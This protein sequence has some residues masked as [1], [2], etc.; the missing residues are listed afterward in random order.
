[1]GLSSGCRGAAAHEA[2]DLSPAGIEAHSAAH[3]TL[4]SA[5]R[6]LVHRGHNDRY[7]DTIGEPA[8]EE[9]AVC[10]GEKWRASPEVD[11]VGAHFLGTL[12]EKLKVIASGLILD[13]PTL[14]HTGFPCAG[15]SRNLLSLLC[16]SSISQQGY[17]SARVDLL[18]SYIK[19]SLMSFYIRASLLA[20]A[21][22]ASAP[23]F[24]QD[25][26][27]WL[28]EEEEEET[29]SERP[30]DDEGDLEDEPDEND[31]SWMNEFE[32]EGEE[33]DFGEDEFEEDRDVSV[34]GEGEDNAQIYRDQM[35]RVENLLPDEEALSWERYMKKY[36]N[37]VFKARID[38]RLTDLEGEMYG[39]RIA[40]PGGSAEDAGKVEM[41]FAQP[42][43]LEN[44]D[45]ITKLRVGFEWG[46]PEYI[47][48]ITDYEHQIFRE[49]SVHV[50]ARNR[51]SSWSIE[52][53]ARYSLIK[54]ARTRTW[55]TAIG[56]VRI[57]TNPIYPAIRPQLAFGQR[58]DLGSTGWL[59]IQLQGGSDLAFVKDANT[60]D[61][62]FDPRVVGGAN[63]TFVPA[64]TVRIYMET[65][66]TMKALAWDG[67]NS[68]RFNVLTFGLK[69]IGRQK[70]GDP[71]YEIGAG[72]TAPYSTNYWGY[73]VGS[74]TGDLNYYL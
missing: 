69:I 7:R 45:P 12:C 8:I 40:S 70:S 54:S 27:D 33:L 18:R 65:S 67:G 38:A 62:L 30:S 50:G 14:V 58:L 31:E 36:P 2:T 59:D 16:H 6:D 52:T 5:H 42:L 21:L 29:P 35:D 11:E 48:L 56:D 72:A 26:D 46:F 23:A 24:A 61:S 71:Q 3:P 57:S 37:S 32:G 17:I 9:L 25:D 10:T 41:Y 60:G 68:F 73:H 64:P 39:E 44:I 1:M 47:N 53:G 55:L 20:V 43:L 51:Y 22:I 66:T 74:I 49:L 19:E 4:S 34:R 15:W 13:G 28:F 63:I